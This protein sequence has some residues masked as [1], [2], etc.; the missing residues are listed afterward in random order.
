MS[1]ITLNKKAFEK[2]VNYYSN[3][4]GGKEKLCIALKDNAYGHGI[5]QMAQLS[6]ENSIKHCMVRDRS[7][8]DIASLYSFETILILYEK[9][10][11]TFPASY[12]FGINS[13]DDI[14][15]YPSET[16]IELKIDTGMSRNGIRID[17]IEEAIK[18]IKKNN[19]ILNGVFTHFCCADEDNDTTAKQEKLFLDGVAM[20]ESKI[21]TPFRTHCANTAGVEKVNNKLYDMARIGIGLYGYSD[22]C[23]KELEPI[24]SLWANKIST[25]TLSK[26]ES[27]G[28]GASYEVQKETQ[29]VSN[30]DIGYGDGFFRVDGT[31]DV[32]IANGK[33][34]L[35]KVSMDSFSVEGLQEEVCVFDDAT[36]LASVH[37]TIHY[38]ILAHLFPRI[39]RV[40]I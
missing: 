40:I 39:K 37:K 16:K 9:P 38:E 30:Y 17:E 21:T 32:F 14:D 34:I 25:R 31:K 18:L 7:E 3:I 26:N 20:I 28:Y 23:Q 36:H 13:L 19:L 4:L 12:I 24:L 5:E 35:G 27:I 6:S 33:P 8:A 1:Y 10:S 15:T 22:F 11:K 2:N 29:I